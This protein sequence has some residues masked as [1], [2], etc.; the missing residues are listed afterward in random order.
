MW[1]TMGRSAGCGD[2]CEIADGAIKSRATRRSNS[3]W[4]S[5]GSAGCPARKVERSVAMIES[6]AFGRGGPV[7]TILPPASFGSLVPELAG[8]NSPRR[9]LRLVFTGDGDYRV[10]HLLR[11][12]FPVLATIG[13]H[14]RFRRINPLPRS[15]CATKRYRIS[16]WKYLRFS[17]TI[18]EM[19]LTK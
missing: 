14:R 10:E 1:R 18:L 7:G 16:K 5:S 17:K 6:F 8:F 13:K 9:L 3:T 19:I 2:R 4:S 12:D 15:P 11:H